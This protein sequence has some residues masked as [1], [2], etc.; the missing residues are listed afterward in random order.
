MTA[1]AK[2]RFSEVVR[3]AESEA[4]EIYR[5]DELVAAVISAES[6]EE[7]RAW[8]ASRRDRT[9]GAAASEIREIC[10]RYDYELQT[11]ER[12]DRDAWPDESL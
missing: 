4:Q 7:Y 9:L 6:F 5:R 12:R 1:E 10:A 2:Q 3:L 8:Q 11:G